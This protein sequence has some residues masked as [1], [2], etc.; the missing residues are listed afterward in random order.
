MKS[1]TQ[2][3]L[4]REFMKA[5]SLKDPRLALMF[6]KA[7]LNLAKMGAQIGGSGVAPT[8]DNPEIL[9][10][11]KKGLEELI[12]AT[13]LP[14]TSSRVPMPKVLPARTETPQ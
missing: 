11:L 6:I 12:E 1:T 13:R 9:E 2:I 10:A 3:R 5:A 4:A 14:R 8:A 7:R